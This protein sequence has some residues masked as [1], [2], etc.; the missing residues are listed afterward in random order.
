M[1]KYV[2][3]CLAIL[4]A[5]LIPG[6]MVQAEGAPDD[7]Y[8]QSAVLMDADT[9]RILFESHHKPRTPLFPFLRRRLN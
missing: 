3:N 4:L 5:A 8:A 6:T 2:K 1:K 9:G 7:L